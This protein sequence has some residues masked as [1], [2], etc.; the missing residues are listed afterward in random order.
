MNKILLGILILTLVACTQTIDDGVTTYT[1]G[2]VGPLTGDGAVYGLPEQ[3]VIEKAVADLNEKWAAK[4]LRLKIIYEDGTCTGKGALTAAQKLVN[5]DG[6]KV[7]RGGLCSSETL[8]MAPFTE[9]NNV[10]VF[11]SLS[12][13]PEVTNAGDFVFRNYPSDTAQVAAIS[14]YMIS[15][16]FEKVAILSENTDYAQALREGYL[17][18]FAEEGISIVAD[19]RVSS[20]SRDVRS[21]V[22]K[23]VAA[24]PDAVIVLPQTIPVAGIFLTQLYEAKLDA[25]IFTSEVVGTPESV[26]TYPEASE[27]IIFPELDFSG[28]NNPAYQAMIKETNCDIGAYC[29]VAYDGI[30][31]LGEVLEKCGENTACLRDTLYATKNWQGPFGDPITF[32]ENGDVAGTF[33]IKQVI[34]G[35]IVQIE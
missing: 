1:I 3:R 6:V 29:P 8:G 7:I 18:V 23:I 14:E 30:F 28:A 19:E 33:V 9:A 13:S 16:K 22:T 34:D 10:L 15:K 32:D 25:Q 20:E 4:N 11:S 21:E 27:N 24:K 5:V 26:N 35:K 17:S 2:V 31:L 12:S